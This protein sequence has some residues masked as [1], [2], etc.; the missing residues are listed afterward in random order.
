MV[1][2]HLYYV[3]MYVGMHIND[4]VNEYMNLFYVRAGFCG[5]KSRICFIT[6]IDL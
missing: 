1:S 5:G 2:W 4:S 6:W 3:L